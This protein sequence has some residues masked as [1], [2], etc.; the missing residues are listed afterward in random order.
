M[1]KYIYIYVLW[2]EISKRADKGKLIAHSNSN[3]LI[4]LRQSQSSPAAQQS[5]GD[6]YS[7]DFSVKVRLLKMVLV[8]F[9]QWDFGF[10]ISSGR[11]IGNNVSEPKKDIYAFCQM[12]DLT[13]DCILLYIRQLIFGINF[14][15]SVIYICNLIFNFFILGYYMIICKTHKKSGS[16]VL[17][18]HGQWDT[19]SQKVW[20]LKLQ[21][22][23]KDGKINKTKKRYG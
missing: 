21:E 15:F 6:I 11:K 8:A 18:I 13:I 3:A 7:E 16:L 4:W 10:Q 14:L 1:L 20:M 22:Y 19:T 23:F 12:K 17:S 5:E 2:L 9:Q